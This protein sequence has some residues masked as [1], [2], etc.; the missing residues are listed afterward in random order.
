MTRVMKTDFSN[1]LTKYSNIYFNFGFVFVSHGCLLSTQPSQVGSLF[2]FLA[3]Q[4]AKHENRI[5]VNKVLFEQVRAPYFYI[6]VLSFFGLIF[7]RCVCVRR[8]S[9]VVVSTSIGSGSNLEQ[10]TAYYS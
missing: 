1:F 6:G 4:M 5:H 10:V 2:T 9:L 8:G 3:R 7:C